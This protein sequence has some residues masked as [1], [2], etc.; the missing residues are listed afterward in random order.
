MVRGPSSLDR[1]WGTV[2]P[3]SHSGAKKETLRCPKEESQGQSFPVVSDVGQGTFEG[4]LTLF[5]IGRRDRLL[6][7]GRG[8]GG[9]WGL[10]ERGK[11]GSSNL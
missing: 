11:Y 9:W 10:T 5:Q 3:P 4:R 1:F 8:G 7:P 6:G 2:K